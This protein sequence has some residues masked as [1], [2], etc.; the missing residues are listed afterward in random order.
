MELCLGVLWRS[1]KDLAGDLCQGTL[2]CNIPSQRLPNLA[3]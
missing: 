1:K 2:S 3:F